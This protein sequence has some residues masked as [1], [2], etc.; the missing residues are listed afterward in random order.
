MTLPSIL[1]GLIISALLGALFHLIMGGNLGR[2]IL[3]IL[4]AV[5]GFWVGHFI[6]GWLD[7]TF[8]SVGDLHVGLGV[9]F[10]L[11]F[12]AVGYWLSLVQIERA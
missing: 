4:V 9:I 7:W 1:L 8:L 6:A 3:Y 11:L 12:I 5:V 10:T 2:L